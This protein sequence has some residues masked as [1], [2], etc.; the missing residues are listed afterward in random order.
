MELRQRIMGIQTKLQNTN[1]R[2]T[3]F[4]SQV[5]NNLCKF[6]LLKSKSKIEKANK[7][8]IKNVITKIL[9]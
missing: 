6:N 4:E 2:I 5:E 9:K 8:V 7:T 1:V 3:T